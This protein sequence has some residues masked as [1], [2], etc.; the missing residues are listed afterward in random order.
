[1]HPTPIRTP[2][3]YVREKAARS[4]TSLHYALL[5][6][7]PDSR[8]AVTAWLACCREVRL[9][10]HEVQDPGVAATKLAWWAKEVDAA[11]AGTASHPALLALLPHARA[12]AL[13]PQALRPLI[14]AGR[15]DLEQSRVLD[16]P[17][18]ERYLDL[19][20]GLPAEAA[21][22][23]LGD[24]RPSALAFAH[25]LGVAMHLTRLIRDVGAHARQG[26]IYLPV[27]E[28]QQHGVK[29]HEI[30]KRDAPWGYGPAY[31]ELMRFQAARA[32]RLHDEAL[33]L[34]PPGER[35][36]L[37]P[38]LAL[39]NQHRRLLQELARGGFPVL[40]QRVALTPVRKLWIA[41]RTHWTGR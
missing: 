12:R 22:R 7:P 1:M 3:D 32:H 6:V 27:S 10:V 30:L 2:A 8:D 5:F 34:L 38:L 16:W 15:I 13:G 41:T 40:H 18:L 17:G 37:K 20:S 11:F 33:A 21:A 35:R 36:V 29:A 24:D 4:G 19:A 28:L 25:R 14:E 26:R 39:A 9:V 31:L 23:L